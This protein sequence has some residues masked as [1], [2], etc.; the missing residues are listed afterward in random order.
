[1]SG[2]RRKIALALLALAC[3]ATPAYPAS[4]PVVVQIAYQ[5]TTPSGGEKIWMEQVQITSAEAAEKTCAAAS[6]NGR[7]IAKYLVANFR[8]LVGH[9]YVSAA[10]V[11]ANG[12]IKMS[13]KPFGPWRTPD[14]AGVA[15][16][17]KD[18]S[19]RMHPTIIYDLRTPMSMAQC[20]Q[21]LRALASRFKKNI[22]D[23]IRD[24]DGMQFVKSKCAFV[25]GFKL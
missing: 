7:K 10:C 5:F 16:Y 25:E 13:N 12:E 22:K 11:M 6:K 21:Q 17:Y 23:N 20:Q 8:A 19:G 2:I 3:V 24:F 15:L 18:A 9:T 14:P 1:M 4:T